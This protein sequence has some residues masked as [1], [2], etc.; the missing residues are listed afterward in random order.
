MSKDQPP[1]VGDQVGIEG[2]IWTVTAIDPVTGELTV[3][4]RLLEEEAAEITWMI[5]N[6]DD[7]LER[8]L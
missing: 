4:R 2:Q 3:E 7:R 6:D 1:T 5:D 8:I